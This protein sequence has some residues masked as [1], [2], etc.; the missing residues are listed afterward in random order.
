MPPI[1]VERLD[2]ERF[3]AGRGRRVCRRVDEW[4]APVFEPAYPPLPENS[5]GLFAGCRGG[6]HGVMLE[7][8]DVWG[9]P[10]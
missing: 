1:R 4:R 5:E 3:A 7:V 6:V 10:A 9:L 8:L 2:V